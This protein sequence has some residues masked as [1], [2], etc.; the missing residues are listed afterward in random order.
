MRWVLQRTCSSRSTVRHV[1]HV[2][3][4]LETF[5]SANFRRSFSGLGFFLCFASLNIGFGETITKT[6][7]LGVGV[8]AS[9]IIQSLA[10]KGR[11]T[12]RRLWLH[13]SRWCRGRGRRRPK[14]RRSDIHRCSGRR[15]RPASKRRW[16]AIGKQSGRSL[17]STKTNNQIAEN[18]TNKMCQ[19]AIQNAKGRIKIQ[20]IVNVLEQM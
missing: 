14:R 13:W 18:N 20:R 4:L 6:H 16:V 3:N 9:H 10:G 17:L 11:T 7:R 19:F 2:G 5:F 8:T 15:T 12:A 1:P